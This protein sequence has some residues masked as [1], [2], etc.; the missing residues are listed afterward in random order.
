MILKI[1]QTDFE[2]DD[3]HQENTAHIAEE[4][5]A[6]SYLGPHNQPIRPEQDAASNQADQTGQLH[7]LDKRRQDNKD[8]QH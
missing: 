6:L 7:P 1:L 2:A 4:R 3:K 5:N 8:Q